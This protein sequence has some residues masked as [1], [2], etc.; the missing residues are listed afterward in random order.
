MDIVSV[1][2]GAE[3]DIPRVRQVAEVIARS[4]SLENFA[5]TRMITAILEITRNAFQHG[6]GGR[7]YFRAE[8]S[9]EYAWLK[10]VVEDQGDGLPPD[11]VFVKN[12][13]PYRSAASSSRGMGLGLTG[14][15][16]LA[17]GFD[18]QSSKD[19]TTAELAFQTPVPAGELNSRLDLAQE[20][21]AALSATDPVA[22]LSRQNRELAEAMAE[23]ELLIDEVHHRTGNNLS[24]IISFI[25]LSKRNAKHEETREAMAQ[26]ESRVHSVAKVHQE[27]QRAHLGERIS[28]LPLLENVARH[29][30]DAFSNPELDITINVFGDSANVA[31]SAAID[32]G[33]IVN[34]LVTNSY[35][36]AFEGRGKG[37]VEITFERGP[38]D[39]Y[40]ELTI[41]D[42]GIG[43]PPEM[44]PERSDSLGW[45][46]IR[47]MAT[48]HGGKIATSGDKG[49]QTSIRFPADFASL[50]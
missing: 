49:F 41:A 3:A 18:L 25:Q 39:A 17:D 38:D 13:R 6:G 29:T 48:R 44:K 47:A 27:L 15:Q 45:R 19:G 2:I 22:E 35:K 31:G 8:R 16:S 42:D 40:W 5:R 1:R 11:S 21:L 37:K 7:A 9:G 46:M 36:H 20:K 33:L 50:T 30:Q 28:L 12:R 32:L 43:I 34:E 14:V 10:V 4:F 26:L 24:L 23:R